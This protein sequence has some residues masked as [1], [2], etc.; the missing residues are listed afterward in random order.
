[1]PDEQ[2]T[3]TLSGNWMR[4]AVQVNQQYSP[5]VVSSRRHAQEEDIDVV[6][7]ATAHAVPL[8][9]S[10]G[11][12]PDY[13]T[14]GYSDVP[15]DRTDT[16]SH[17]GVRRNPGLTENDRAVEHSA[18]AGAHIRPWSQT[19]GSPMRGIDDGWDVDLVEDMDEPPSA[20]TAGGREDLIR[21]LNAFPENNPS[22]VMYHSQGWRRATWQNRTMRHPLK[23]IRRKHQFRVNTRIVAQTMTDR[24][25]PDTVPGVSWSSLSRAIKD[26]WSKPRM[27]RSPGYIDEAI[28]RPGSEDVDESQ[29]SVGSFM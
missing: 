4:Q 15:L 7:G 23:R 5:W 17:S 12:V 21:G 18:Y 8:Q 20:R 24:P 28:M 29:A 14:P 3:E 2:Q 1:M 10:G 16:R 22:Q 19:T 26:G 27:R 13:R 9:P 6:R 11:D 25:P